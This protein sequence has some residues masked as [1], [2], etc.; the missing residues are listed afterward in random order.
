MEPL[1]T[2]FAGHRLSSSMGEVLMHGDLDDTDVLGPFPRLNSGRNDTAEST[3]S[4]SYLEW[5]HEKQTK[6][7]R[8][9]S[10]WFLTPSG[11]PSKE[12]AASKSVDF[13]RAANKTYCYS[14][15]GD[16]K[17]TPRTIHDLSPIT[18]VGTSD[19]PSTPLARQNSGS[20]PSSPVGGGANNK[21][22]GRKKSWR[23]HYVR[24]SKSF[25]Q[26]PPTPPTITPPN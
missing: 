20:V 4:L 11:M 26:D 21:A 8:T 23:T 22:I 7:M 24:P 12:N 15:I 14:T 18:S 9:R 17:I 6:R 3:Q 10:E 19:G 5:V 16:E 25:D 1:E 13:G 2:E